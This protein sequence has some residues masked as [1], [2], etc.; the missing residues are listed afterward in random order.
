M[1]KISRLLKQGLFL[2]S[3]LG[4]AGDAGAQAGTIALQNMQAMAAALDSCLFDTTYYVSLENLNDIS[5]INAINAYDSIQDNGGPYVMIPS[6]GTFLPR[7]NL[8]T[9]F[10]AWGGPYITYQ[11]GTTQTGSGPYDQG[12][13][14]DPWGNPY[15]LFNPVGL[16]RGDQ[17]LITLELYG[18]QFDRY[19]IVSLG[20][21]GIKSGD[22]IVYAFN[23]SV[24]GTFLT[25]LKGPGVTRTSPMLSAPAYAMDAGTSLTLRGLNFGTAGP[26]KSVY[27]GS[28]QLTNVLSWTNREIMVQ[29]PPGLSGSGNF[30]VQIGSGSTAGIQATLVAG[31]TAARLWPLYE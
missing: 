5:S 2:V 24:N 20:P 3:T 22:D 1:M 10:N 7:R 18:D 17:G 27:F 13:L 6:M 26:T 29:L 19:T 16:L 11:Q 21:D 12:S 15:Y 9:A 30:R 25:S 28:T 31:P 14:L 23:G 8:A 4:I